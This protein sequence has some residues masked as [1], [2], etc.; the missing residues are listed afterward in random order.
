MI[1]SIMMYAQKPLA[2]AMGMLLISV[3]TVQAQTDFLTPGFG[4]ASPS[5]NA[6]PQAPRTELYEGVVKSNVA[7]DNTV[8]DYTRLPHLLGGRQYI[9]GFGDLDLVNAAFAFG[10]SHMNW[11]GLARSSADEDEL[12]AGVAFGDAFGAGLIL[13][14]NREHIEGGAP[15]TIT[16]EGQGFGLFGSFNLGGS[17]VYGEAALYTGFANLSDNVHNS[18]NPETGDPTNFSKFHFVAGWNMQA[19]AQGD[20]A[21]N[22]ELSFGLSSGEVPGPP[23]FEPS[24]TDIALWFQHGYLM[25]Q[26]DGFSVFA[27]SNNGFVYAAAEQLTA[28]GPDLSGMAFAISPNMAFQKTLPKGFEVQAGIS[29]T[30]AYL[31]GLAGTN[32]DQDETLLITGDTPF[33]RATGADMS[34]GLRWQHENFAFE[35]S[36]QETLLSNGPQ[37]IGGGAPGLFGQIGMTVGF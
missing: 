30:L 25:L 21:M 24:R 16:H 9:A 12:R 8:T 32:L 13:A 3:L 15:A 19:Q 18:I 29:A 35:G 22:A 11:F 26:R 31:S 7:A 5:L 1:K 6:G 33:Q 28:G 20:H 4:Q 27:G 36:V 10:D 2:G 34:V 37:F 23:A 17:S 14:L